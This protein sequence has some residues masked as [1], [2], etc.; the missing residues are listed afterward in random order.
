MDF[1]ALYGELAHG[2]EIVRALLI[3]VTQEQAQIKPSPEFV[4]DP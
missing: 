2:V 4:V 1:E 3:G